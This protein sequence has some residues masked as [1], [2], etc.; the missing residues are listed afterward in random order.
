MMVNWN[1]INFSRREDKQI[2]TLNEV[3]GLDLL[4]C[5]FLEFYC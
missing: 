2:L 5:L 4:N 3:L 1:M